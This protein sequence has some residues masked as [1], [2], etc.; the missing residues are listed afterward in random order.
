MNEAIKR[1]YSDPHW[2]SVEQDIIEYL[3]PIT[4]VNTIDTNQS[5]E[6]VHAEVRARQIAYEKLMA[7][8]NTTGLI[9]QKIK[10]PKKISFR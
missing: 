5:P 6:V 4:D 1:F 8:A 9:R 3:K 7:F 2:E 10:Q